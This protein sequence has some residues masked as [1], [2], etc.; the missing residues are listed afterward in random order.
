MDNFLTFAPIVLIPLIP[1]PAAVIIDQ[2]VIPAL[3][4]GKSSFLA[5]YR[6]LKKDEMPSM[7][8]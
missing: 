8:I 6:K 5:I 4:I 7:R 1:A 3:V 2:Q